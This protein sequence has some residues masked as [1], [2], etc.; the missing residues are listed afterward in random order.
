M[1]QKNL[2]VLEP[3]AGYGS[4]VKALVE[5]LK[6]NS[7]MI[8]MIEL[9]DVSREV[10]E[11]YK[12]T[13][14]SNLKLEDSKDFL[15]YK[16]NEDY[17]LIIMNP[18]FHIKKGENQNTKDV[19][20]S[21]FVLKAYSM[22]KD[23]GEI[24]CITSSMLTRRKNWNKNINIELLKKY[25]SYKWKGEKGGNKLQSFN[26]YRIIKNVKKKKQDGY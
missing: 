2:R 20:D 16:S 26:M 25:E 6:T 12:D 4:I 8:E 24:L 1:N 17:D 13:M 22:L 7:Y 19:F 11:V 15:L 9:N 18:P 23:D 10:L 5:Q 21:D 3:T 14:P